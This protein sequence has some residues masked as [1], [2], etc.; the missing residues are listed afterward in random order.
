MLLPALSLGVG[1]YPGLFRPP[2]PIPA[3][4]RADM[5]ITGALL[6][7]KGVGLPGVN[8][9]VHGTSNGTQTDATAATALKRPTTPP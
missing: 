4:V 2:V 5:T 6:D 9:I 7:E 1:L 3:A 8:V